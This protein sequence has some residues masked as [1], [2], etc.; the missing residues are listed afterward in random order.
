M[1]QGVPNYAYELE[2]AVSEGYLVN[3]RG[4]KRG[5]LILKDGIKY[6]DLSPKEQEQLEKVWEYEQAKK[7]IDGEDYRRDIRSDEIFKYIF[8]LDTIDH[9][10]QDLMENGL[11]VQ[12][13]E[14]IGKTIIFAYNHRHAEMIVERFYALY[15]EYMQARAANSVPLSTTMSPTAKTLSTSSRFVT[16]IHR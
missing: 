1:E 2:D 5:S 4:F 8:N 12:S 6:K 10:L 11:K 14:R 16:A 7:A 15:P 13:G 3:Y 9:V